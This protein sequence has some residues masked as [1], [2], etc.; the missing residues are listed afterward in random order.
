M[1][2]ARIGDWFEIH[3]LS[4]GD[5]IRKRS[6]HHRNRFFVRVFRV[7]EGEFQT[8]FASAKN[9]GAIK[10]TWS[11]HRTNHQQRI[12]KVYYHIHRLPYQPKDTSKGNT[13][14]H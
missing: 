4:T 6:S 14:V 3:Y 8:V 12:G 7:D 10:F 1:P 13:W 5:M 11:E 2:K 9:V